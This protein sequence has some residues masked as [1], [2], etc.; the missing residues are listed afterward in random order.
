MENTF[1][2][3]PSGYHLCFNLP[4]VISNCFPLCNIHFFSQIK[5]LFYKKYTDDPNS[6]EQHI[7]FADRI[8]HINFHLSK[9]TDETYT[10]C[11][12]PVMIPAGILIKDNIF[13]VPSQ[14]CRRR[15]Q[16]RSVI[17]LSIF[18]RTF[19][20]GFPSQ[21]ISVIQNCVTDE[22]PAAEN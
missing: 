5:C 22:P 10:H 11:Q 18:F 15:I 21:E 20:T 13:P 12:N 2:I 19:R 7:Q 16:W 17:L 9:S 6:K 8:W 1:F 3:P 14:L 4:S